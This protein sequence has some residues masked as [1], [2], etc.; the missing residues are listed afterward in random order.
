MRENGSQEDGQASSNLLSRYGEVPTVQ[1]ELM[2]FI[3]L[4]VYFYLANFSRLIN[5]VEVKVH[6]TVI[7]NI[8]IIT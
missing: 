4:F 8:I 3:H 5:H 1:T 6:F 2:S 7:H